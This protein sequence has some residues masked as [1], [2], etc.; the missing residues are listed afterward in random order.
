[1]RKSA[2]PQGASALRRS[3]GHAP[4]KGPGRS[5]KTRCT[6][7]SRSRAPSST[8]TRAAHTVRTGPLRLPVSRNG[9]ARSCCCRHDERSLSAIA[10]DRAPPPFT[11]CCFCRHREHTGG[12]HLG[13]E[14]RA[15]AAKGR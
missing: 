1:M 14:G 15:D 12:Q 8:T 9:G 13:T 3:I 5:E 4:R 2:F 11:C 6:R 7:E 10:L